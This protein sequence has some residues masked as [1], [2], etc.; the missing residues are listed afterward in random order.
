M[1]KLLWPGVGF[2][3][4][5]LLVT[6]IFASSLNDT[7]DLQLASNNKPAGPY[8]DRTGSD[9]PEIQARWRNLNTGND[10]QVFGFS[11]T[12]AANAAASFM[13]N[14]GYTLSFSSFGR[15]PFQQLL[16]ATKDGNVNAITTTTS[17]PVTALP[18]PTTLL[19]LGSGLAAL[20]AGLRKRKHK[21]K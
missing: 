12:A 10:A 2:G 8:R 1:K 18:E 11:S 4:L 16:L 13:Q 19:L 9:S 5:V 20:A 6:P 3:V 14:Q 7:S 15:A 17:R 21:Q